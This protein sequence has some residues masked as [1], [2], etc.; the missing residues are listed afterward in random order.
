MHDPFLQGRQDLWP[1]STGQSTS[2]L[3]VWRSVAKCC[4][5]LGEAEYA[6]KEREEMLALLETGISTETEEARVCMLFC[7]RKTE[8][9]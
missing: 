3:S 2:S 6:E 8:R 1:R 7:G 5:G 4:D 9:I